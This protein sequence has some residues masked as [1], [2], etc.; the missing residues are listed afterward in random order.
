MV[1]KALLVAVLA[2]L[3]VAIIANNRNNQQKGAAESVK[4][5]VWTQAAPSEV[6]VPGPVPPEEAGPAKVKYVNGEITVQPLVTCLER[7]SG[8][9]LAVTETQGE[10][11]DQEKRILTLEGDFV[12]LRYRH[13]HVGDLPQNSKDTCPRM[14]DCWD[15]AATYAVTRHGV[16]L[17]FHP[18]K[19]HVFHTD[20]KADDFIDT[21]NTGLA[22]PECQ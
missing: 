17:G 1:K 19:G 2:L 11:L 3:A 9:P 13:F 20:K 7:L 15:T 6:R 10:K 12:K 16:D 18:A 22:M 21:A 14:K 5:N 8:R 4:K